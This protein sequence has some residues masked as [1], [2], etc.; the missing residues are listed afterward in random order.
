M[1]DTLKQIFKNDNHTAMKD[2]RATRERIEVMQSLKVSTGL[3]TRREKITQNKLIIDKKNASTT[4]GFEDAIL[5]AYNHASSKRKTEF[6]K[7]WVKYIK[8]GREINNLH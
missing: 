2:A 4:Q 8:I 6:Q 3:I 7:I 1:E 5:K